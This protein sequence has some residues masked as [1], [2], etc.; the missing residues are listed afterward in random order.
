MNSAAHSAA[1][2]DLAKKESAE[3]FHGMADLYAAMRGRPILVKAF[4]LD[5]PEAPGDDS[6]NVKTVHFA[7]H[8]QGFHNLMA[9]LALSEGREWVQVGFMNQRQIKDPR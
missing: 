8:G 7:R 2:L 6:G 1:T 4:A 9:D 3:H 5:D